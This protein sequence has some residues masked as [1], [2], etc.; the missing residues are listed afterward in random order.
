MREYLKPGITYYIYF[1]FLEIIADLTRVYSEHFTKS[2]FKLIRCSRMINTVKDV[3]E[4][5]L[6]VRN[7]HEGK[8]NHRG[9]DETLQYLKRNY[10]W[11]NMKDSVSR[12]INSCDIC[13]RTKYAR[14]KPYVPLVLT[15]TPSR[16]FQLIHVDVFTYDTKL[17]FTLVDAFS[18]FAQALPLPGKTALHICNALIKY[19][20]CSG[21]P[22][23][24]ILDSGREFYNETV[25]ELLKI[26]KI[27]IHFTTPG[28]HESNSIVERFHSTLIEHLTILEEI[29]HLGTDLVHYAVLGYNSSIHSATGFTPFELV[30]GH[31]NSRNPDEIFTPKELFTEYVQSHKEKVNRV[32]DNVQR[33]LSEQKE[34]IIARANTE[35]N[36]S[37]EFQSN[38]IVYKKKL[39]TRNKKHNKFI[40]PFII[41]RLLN[42]NK[43]EI[44]NSKGKLEIVHIKKL[45]KPP[46][47]QG[48][49]EYNTDLEPVDGPCAGPSSR[50]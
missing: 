4:Q 42:H 32:Y 20:T 21:I 28:H 44:R 33:K 38:Q 2:M 23:N 29:Y 16:P 5:I 18:K 9:V 7:H 48:E 27:N 43:V 30:F 41:T 19:F 1:A 17:Y 10:Y 26:H 13:L 50:N 15:E 12:Y 24:I 3:D 39:F 6:F 11:L 47:L 8:T 49:N 14:K 46:L 36:T 25:K 35:G 37:K 31:T 22:Q 40:G 34:K 45:R